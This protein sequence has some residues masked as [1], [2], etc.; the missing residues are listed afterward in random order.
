MMRASAL[1]TA[2]LAALLV[3]GL[4]PSAAFGGRA[5]ISQGAPKRKKTRPRKL[6]KRKDKRRPPAH[7]SSTAPMHRRKEV[8]T[9]PRDFLR[10]IIRGGDI[11]LP[12]ASYRH[13]PRI[14][15]K[16]YKRRRSAQSV[17]EALR[18]DGRQ[19]AE[20]RSRELDAELSKL[21]V[22]AESRS[23][24]LSYFEHHLVRQFYKAHQNQAS[25]ERLRVHRQ[26]DKAKGKKLEK[27]RRDLQALNRLE[28]A[29]AILPVGGRMPLNYEYAGQTYELSGALRDKYPRSVAFKL[30]GFPDFSPY[31][32]ARV[33]VPDLV[34]DTSTDFAKANKRSGLAETPDG[35][36]WHHHEDGVTME[37]VPTDL[38]SAVGHTGGAA[39]LANRRPPNIPSG[40][41]L[42]GLELG[43]QSEA[44]ASF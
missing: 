33:Q 35:F 28:S 36:T 42:R 27:L 31:A 9:D 11:G 12:Q 7:R 1:S 29:S 17:R 13:S 25:A 5:R 4:P 22:D 6:L 34:G 41:D 20:T 38:H 14:P 40:I 39:I 3:L 18:R 16:L 15:T 32:H 43:V 26:L 23:A 19:L 24:I 21:G 8:P 2:A 44:P 37:L 10:Q 30:N